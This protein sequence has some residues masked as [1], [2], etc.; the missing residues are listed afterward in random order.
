MLC[1]IGRRHRR[2]ALSRDTGTTDERIAQ[3]LQSAELELLSRAPRTPLATP[4][5]HTSGGG[6]GGVVDDE[7]F[8]PIPPPPPDCW[9][10]EARPAHRPAETP[11]GGGELDP[12]WLP[13]DTAAAAVLPPG[14]F[15]DPAEDDGAAAAAAAAPTGRGRA[16]GGE[17][18]PAARVVAAAAA[19]D[20]GDGGG[21][22]A[23]VAA[24]RRRGPAAVP[25][26][27]S[28]LGVVDLLANKVARLI[29][30]LVCG[31]WGCRSPLLGATG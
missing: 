9:P 21:G 23:A 31:A 19:A 15:L 7:L 4:A 29:A 27:V 6:G 16:P 25:S 12:F 17:A 3:A 26:A 18:Q 2:L 14:M 8:E 5:N 30:R 24:G 1:A 20:S 13:T 11:A 28:D 10:D 22:A